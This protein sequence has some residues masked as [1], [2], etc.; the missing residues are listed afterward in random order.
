LRATH[1]HQWNW[2]SAL[3]ALGLAEL[4]HDRA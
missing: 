3:A 4:D 2:D 1:P